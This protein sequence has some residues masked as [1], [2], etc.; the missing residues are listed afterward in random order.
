MPL[1][2]YHIRFPDPDRPGH[3][4]LCSTKKGS[5]LRLPD[6]RL[7]AIL[8]GEPTGAER[9]TM[10]R[11]ALWTEAPD[12]GRAE[13]A[14]VVDRTNA[15]SRRFAA[16]VVLT[17]ACDLACPYCFEGD[18]RDG[19]EMDEATAR[20]L[21]EFVA[22]EQVGRGR[23]V[24][25]RFYGGEPLMAVPRLLSIARPLKDAADAAGTGFSFG[26]VTNGVRLT[27][28]TVASLLPLGLTYAQVTLDGPRAIHDR[29]R[30]SVS[31]SGSYD[32]ILRN[33]AAVHDLLTLRLGGNFTRENYRAFPRVLDDLL[34]AGVDPGRF[35]PVEFA[36]VLPK[37]G[38]VAGHEGGSCLSAAGEPWAGEAAL[39]LREE[40]L[41]RGFAVRK[42]A[43]GI[44]P[45]ELEHR[46]VVDRDGTLY[47][48]PAF[49]GWPEMAVGTLADGVRDHAATHRPGFWRNDACLDCPY[50]PLCFGGCRLLSMFRDGAVGGPECRK[51]SL[52]AALAETVRLDLRYRR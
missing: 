3:T 18:F 12:G 25:I 14:A 20:L 26:L 37:S 7:A 50:L 29:Q 41:R 15:E 10:A 16:T 52:D 38:R 33:V 6:A 27:R 4:V 40:T 23:D 44:C 21:V 1:S 42:I 2:R 9:R 17:Y 51:A 5:L 22:R 36:P 24:E 32:A 31:G 45:V 46:L 35:D 43:M 49:L 28:D 39:F 30:P 11:L 47:K 13:L 34:A 8:A 19:S 48:C